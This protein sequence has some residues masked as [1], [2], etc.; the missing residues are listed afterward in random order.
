[1]I[2]QKDFEKTIKKFDV[3]EA[4]GDFYPLFLNL[5]KKGFEIE[6]FLLMLATWNFASFRYAIK[7]FDL[8]NF[9]KTISLIKKRSRKLKG[10][11][12]RT[13]NFSSFRKEIIGIFDPLY[14]IKG[15]KS[16]GIPKL[17]HLLNPQVFVMWDSYIRRHYGFRRGDAGDYLDFLVKM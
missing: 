6:A 2:N 11:S 1:M 17:M 4:R 9:K 15:I 12:F 10:K 5:M 16:T 8:A 13:I 14:Q 3:L 7:E